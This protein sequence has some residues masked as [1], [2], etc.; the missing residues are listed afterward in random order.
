MPYQTGTFTTLTN[1][2]TTIKAFAV[3]NGWTQ[4]GNILDNGSAFYDLQEILETEGDTLAC[5]QGT[6]RSG[7]TLTGP[8]AEAIRIAD[9]F[10]GG[11]VFP[12]TYH[13]FSHSAPDGIF[14]VIKYNNIY[15]QHMAFGEIDKTGVWGGGGFCSSTTMYD[16][17]ENVQVQIDPNGLTWGNDG[18]STQKE[19]APGG[20]M[21]P[22]LNQSDDAGSLLHCD[23]DGETWFRSGPRTAATYPHFAGSDLAEYHI[24][25]LNP[26]HQQ[27]VLG[28]CVVLV[29][30]P[31]GFCSVVGTVPHIRY[32]RVDNYVSGDITQIGS[33][34]W[35]VFPHTNKVASVSGW[36]IKYDGP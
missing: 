29:T 22:N 26:V 13:L 9:W 17:Y 19:H 18:S 5:L 14:C 10:D 20:F 3:A 6:G 28:P 16:N 24:R 23:L 21:F 27:P 2:D 35:M 15:H 25:I 34:K 8:T 30:R 31:S 12:G 7:G 1:L 11:M 33:Q 32:L 36:C 4:S